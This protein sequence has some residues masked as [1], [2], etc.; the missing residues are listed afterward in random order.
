MLVTCFSTA[1]WVTK[2][3][4]PIAWF[5]RPSAISSSTSRSRGVSSASGSSFRRRPTSCETIVGSSAEP[6]SPTRRTAAANSPTSDDAVLQQVAD[7][8][9]ALGEEVERVLRLDV[10][11]EDEHAGRRM[12]LADLPRRAE[13]LVGVR[14]RHPDVDD[15]DVGRV[16]AHL[17]QQLVGGPGLA[18]DL[19]A[20]LLEQLRD[21]LAEQDGV[22]GEDDAH[23]GDAT[24]VSVEAGNGIS[25]TTTRSAA[26]R[27]LDSQRAVERRDAVGEAAQARAGGAVGAAD[28]VVGDLDHDGAVPLGDRD[29]DRRRVARA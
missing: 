6:P 20:G 12:L 13:A 14:R 28:A 11:R 26:R 9:G 18:D 25:A 7:A 22:V 8:L 1:R 23:G 24:P 5:E 17:Q 10:L 4:S 19:E 16:R 15:R 29:V 3:R 2:S 21:A 27:A